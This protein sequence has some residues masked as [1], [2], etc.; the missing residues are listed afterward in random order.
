MKEDSYEYYADCT[1]PE[2]DFYHQIVHFDDDG[3]PK[4]GE[5]LEPA[6]VEDWNESK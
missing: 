6:Q 5:E 3:C 4:C 1:N 2:C